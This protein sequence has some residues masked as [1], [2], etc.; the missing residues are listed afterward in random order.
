MARGKNKQSRG[1]H[2]DLL[3]VGSSKLTPSSL[4]RERESMSPLIAAAVD[5]S[6]VRFLSVSGF[7]MHAQRLSTTEHQTSTK[8]REASER[9][10]YT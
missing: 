6:C 1:R 8:I 3:R 4:Q 9:D 10:T 5:R 2:S 7:V